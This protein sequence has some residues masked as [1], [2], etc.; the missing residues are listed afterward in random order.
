MRNGFKCHACFFLILI[1]TFFSGCSS[2]LGWGVLLWSTEDPA[3]PSGTVLPVFIK[4]N[5]NKVWVIGI[6]EIWQNSSDGL[7]KMEVPLAHLELIGSRRKALKWAD[8]FAAYA[9]T[10]AENLQD[11]LPIRDKPDNN[12]RRTYRLRSGEIIKIIS[13]VE[14]V[15]AI[16]TTGDPL[17]GDWY[18]VLTE[19]GNMGY[20]FSY[21]LRIFEYSGGSLA[22]EAPVAS[23]EIIIDTVLDTLMAKKWVPEL[24]FNMVNNQKINLEELQ[25]RW[26]FDPGQ[27]TGVARI[28][29]PNLDRNFPYTAIRPDGT[30]AWRFE[31]ANL[32]LQ[33]RSESTIAVQYVEGSGSTRTLLFCSLP[34]EIEDLIIQENA[35]RERLYN[36]IYH[37]G[38]VF[39]SNN[40][41][42]IVF[43]EGGRFSWSG[44][45]LLVPRYI[46]ESAAPQNG[47]GTGNI[48]MNLF[49]GTALEDRY[50]GAFTMRFAGSEA[51]WLR[52]MYFLDDQGFRIEIVPE[53]VIED[54]TVL[55]RDS[56][57]MVLYFFR[58][59]ELW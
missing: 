58:D 54:V 40:Y 42:T 53:S 56:S 2:R 22:A 37:K 28:Y 51:A 25:R 27:D 45:D 48:Q 21:R 19:D 7:D 4:S 14:G 46:P 55:R 31:G 44:Y 38:P 20:C 52:C 29:I 3:I 36:T 57:P 15:S 35:R 34:V 5:L 18:H 47:E 50:T 11:G 39:T 17:P 10:Y 59:S 26:H 9:L 16:S 49:L 23:N 43:R 12:A 33:L 30:R 24:Y 13:P 8:D 1:V 6:P 32:L 41:G